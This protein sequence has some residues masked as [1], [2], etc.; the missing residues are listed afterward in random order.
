VH[1][2]FLQDKFGAAPVLGA[3]SLDRTLTQPPKEAHDGKP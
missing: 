1:S 3:P 2:R